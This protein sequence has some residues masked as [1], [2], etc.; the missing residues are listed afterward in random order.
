RRP[1]AHRLFGLSLGQGL[2]E[3]LRGEI[4]LD[5]AVQATEMDGLWMIT[6]GRA[7]LPAL[8]ALAKRAGPI[9]DQFKRH[10]D[11]IIVDSP[12]VLPVADAL[13]LGKHV[14]AV[15]FSILRDV[16]RLPAVQAATER[17]GM[18]G[19]RILGAVL[20]GVRQEGYKSSYRYRYVMAPP[21]ADGV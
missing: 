14:D 11:V 3:L 18:L 15:V 12:T 6:A 2:G 10:Y 1:S 4:N 21:S 19:L 17:I 13:L 20:S 8:Q 7:D 16:S 5:R 9:F